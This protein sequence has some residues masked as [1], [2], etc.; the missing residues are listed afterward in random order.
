MEAIASCLA[1][2]V[3]YF[4]NTA[5]NLDQLCVVGGGAKNRLLEATDRRYNAVPTCF[6]VETE[7]AAL[8]ASFQT[9][10]AAEKIPIRDYIAVQNIEMEPHVV[11]P[12]PSN[13]AKYEEA[14]QRYR[15]LGQRGSHM[16]SRLQKYVYLHVE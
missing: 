15:N 11:Q 3:Q 16:L 7:R 8:G 14:F 9:A 4:R 1:D 13:Y 12:C 6:P 10:A 5:K 2:T